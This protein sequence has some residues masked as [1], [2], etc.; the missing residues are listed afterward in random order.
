MATA[1]TKLKTHAKR[2]G[3]IAAGTLGTLLVLNTLARRTRIGSQ[4]AGF[5]GR[6]V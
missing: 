2:F 5:I 3:L 4:I 6:G 1:N